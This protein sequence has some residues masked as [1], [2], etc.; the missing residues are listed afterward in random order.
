MSMQNCTVHFIHT[1][2]PYTYK[3]FVVYYY[4]RCKYE[5]AT[6]EKSLDLPREYLAL[7][8]ENCAKKISLPPSIYIQFKPNIPTTKL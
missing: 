6:E 4:R 1:A 3:G 5:T 2:A 7:N 8:T